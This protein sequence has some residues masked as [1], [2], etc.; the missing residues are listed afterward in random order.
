MVERK[1]L[2]RVRAE[3]E[4]NKNNL[5]LSQQTTRNLSYRVRLLPL[6]PRR[7]PHPVVR[8]I[9]IASNSHQ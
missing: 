8:T 4:E 2:S 5:L 7:A 9:L 1:Y 6:L 3:E